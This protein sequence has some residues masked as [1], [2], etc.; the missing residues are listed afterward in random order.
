MLAV[1][2]I[3]AFVACKENKDEPQVI[4]NTTVIEKEVAAP[5]EEDPNGTSVSI[6]KNGVEFSTKSGDNKTEIKIKDE[7]EK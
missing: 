6:D 4:E 5:V 3:T 1:F 7:V 2:T